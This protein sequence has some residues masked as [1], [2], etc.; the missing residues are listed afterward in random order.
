MSNRLRFGCAV[1]L[2]MASG[3]LVAA[4]TEGAPAKWQ[5]PAAAGQ[6]GESSGANQPDVEVT[7]VRAWLDIQRKG[8]QATPH[9]KYVTGAEKS[10][11]RERYLES[12][13][14]AIPEQFSDTSFS[15]E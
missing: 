11:I 12:F 5:Q 10:R 1:I 9:G 14:H 6:T 8:Q 15:A 7:S 2:Y 13:S 4:S 3:A